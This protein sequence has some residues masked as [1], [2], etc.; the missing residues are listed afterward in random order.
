MPSQAKKLRLNNKIIMVEGHNPNSKLVA[1]LS[2]TGRGG[3]K[4][5]ESWRETVKE[6]WKESGGKK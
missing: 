2:E 6:E 5:E 1:C 3:E 4:M